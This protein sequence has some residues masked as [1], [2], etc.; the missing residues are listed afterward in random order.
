MP[1]SD[2]LDNATG[3]KEEASSTVQGQLGIRAFSYEH[4]GD[5]VRLAAVQAA[6]Q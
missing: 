1:D 4:I 3:N 2:I 5:E 6:G